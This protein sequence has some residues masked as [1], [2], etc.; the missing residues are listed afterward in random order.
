MYKEELDTSPIILIL[1]NILN[2]HYVA[3]SGLVM[4]VFAAL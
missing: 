4:G 1:H 3:S 2:L